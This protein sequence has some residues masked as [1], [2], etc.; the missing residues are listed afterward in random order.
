[1]NFHDK[2]F[3]M[4]VNE[5]Q[6]ARLYQFTRE[7][8]V[9]YYDLQTELVDHL[10]FGI[11]TQWQENPKL[12]FE[13][14]LQNEFKKFGI[15]GFSNVVEKRQTAMSKRYQQFIWQQFK[16]YFKLP[17][18]VLTLSSMV[19]LFGMFSQIHKYRMLAFVGIFFLYVGVYFWFNSQK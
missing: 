4:K 17:K 10:A 13:I 12:D 3:E 16:E 15:F 6:T 18:I 19:I 2:T 7:H 8:F 11:E 9:E 1:M 14:A 5:S